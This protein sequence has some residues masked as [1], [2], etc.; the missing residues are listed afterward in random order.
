MKL[1][2]LRG[3]WGLSAPSVHLGPPHILETEGRLQL[4]AIFSMHV[5]TCSDTTFLFR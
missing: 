5:I 1:F 2:P 4:F 3:V